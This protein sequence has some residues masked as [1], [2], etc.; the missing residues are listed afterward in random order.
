MMLQHPGVFQP[1]GP[2]GFQNSYS[3]L[4]PV[5]TGCGPRVGEGEPSLGEGGTAVGLYRCTHQADG[6]D[7]GVWRLGVYIEARV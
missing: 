7:A 2:K 1:E 3:D 6:L 5:M 4:I